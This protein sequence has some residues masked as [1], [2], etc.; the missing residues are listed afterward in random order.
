MPPF[1][2]AEALRRHGIPVAE[3]SAVD[4]ADFE[5]LNAARF[6]VLVLWNGNAFPQPALSNLRAFP[7]R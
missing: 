6:A 4:L 5:K 2:A 3:L 7:L 1:K